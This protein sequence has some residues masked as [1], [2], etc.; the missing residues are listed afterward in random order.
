MFIHLFSYLQGSVTVFV[1]FLIKFLCCSVV[2]VC[3]PA[4]KRTNLQTGELHGTTNKLD[5]ETLRLKISKGDKFKLES[6][7]C[8]LFLTK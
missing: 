3:K 1:L 2:Y 6:F 5:I 7:T 4:E 8:Q